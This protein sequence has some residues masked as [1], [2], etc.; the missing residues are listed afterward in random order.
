MRNRVFSLRSRNE[1]LSRRRQSSI[2]FAK[3]FRPAYARSLQRSIG[4]GETPN[5]GTGSNAEV[6]SLPVAQ[7]RLPAA[8]NYEYIF[9]SYA[10]NPCDSRIRRFQNAQSFRTFHSNSQP[11][12]FDSSAPRAAFSAATGNHKIAITHVFTASPA[13]S[14]DL[15]SLELATAPLCRN[16]KPTLRWPCTGGL[17]AP[18]HLNFCTAV[19]RL[20]SFQR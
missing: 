11:G 10:A 19:S 18:Q 17:A 5:A 7:T 20:Y 12:G 16:V 6:R 13:F 14:M 4:G 8:C 1:H 9:I 2:D 3:T 15:V